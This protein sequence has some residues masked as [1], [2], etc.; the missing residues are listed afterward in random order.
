MSDR[1][2]KILVDRFRDYI[3]NEFD[4]DSENPNVCVA[5]YDDSFI[6]DSVTHIIVPLNNV[7]QGSRT[8][9]EKVERFSD[10]GK[11]ECKSHKGIKDAAPRWKA[12]IKLKEEERGR[13]RRR[14]HSDDA[15]PQADRPPNVSFFFFYIFLLLLLVILGLAK[16]TRDEWRFIA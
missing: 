10:A 13:N 14:G 7:N 12:Y 6:N 4:G 5:N 2:R 11:V 3:A 8:F 1:E 15:L 9:I 16:T